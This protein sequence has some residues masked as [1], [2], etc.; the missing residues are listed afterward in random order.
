MVQVNRNMA[1]TDHPRFLEDNTGPEALPISSMTGF[2]RQ[3]GE[4]DPWHWAWELRSVNNKGLDVRLRLPSSLDAIEQP[5]RSQITKHFKRGSISASLRLDRADAGGSISINREALEQ[6]LALQAELAGKIDAAPPRIEGLLAVR[7]VVEMA[8]EDQDP[9]AQKTLAAEIIQ[10]LEPALAALA[11]ARDEEGARL[12][13]FLGPQMDDIARLIADA[14]ET[15]E[16]QPARLKEKLTA[17]LALLVDANPPLSEERLAQELA[18]LA[19]RADV[20]EETD[21]LA[22]HVAAARDLL[23]SDEPVG[24]R[25]DFLCQEFNREANTLCSKAADLDLTNIG[26][27]LKAAIEQFREQVQNVE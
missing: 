27:A 2:A 20:R 4:F 3:E 26:L 10:S 17:Q 14:Q 18:V 19:A 7:G 11:A 24:R 15:G 1:P 22:A 16:A 25:L 23:D 8:E 5:A 12:A 21:R 6:V 9:A 13:A